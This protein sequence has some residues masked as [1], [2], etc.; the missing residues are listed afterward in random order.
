M[1]VK[2]LQVLGKALFSHTDLRDLTKSNNHANN[3]I[4]G[5]QMIIE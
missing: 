2:F 3:N 1:R 5:L 4:D